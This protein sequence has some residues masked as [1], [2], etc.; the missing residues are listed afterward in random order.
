MKPVI[1]TTAPKTCSLVL[2]KSK[3]IWLEKENL[4]RIEKENTRLLRKMQKIARDRG[5]VDNHNDYEPKSLNSLRRKHEVE[6]IMADNR[7]LVRRL[8]EKQR[9]K[10]TKQWEKEWSETLI[11]M[12]HI[13]R[14]PSTWWKEEQDKNDANSQEPEDPKKIRPLV[15]VV[16]DEAVDQVSRIDVNRMKI[17]RNDPLFKKDPEYCK[18]IAQE[19][20]DNPPDSIRGFVASI[21]QTAIYRVYEHERAITR[22]KASQSPSDDGALSLTAA[23]ILEDALKGISNEPDSG[24][25]CSETVHYN[26]TGKEEIRLDDE[27]HPSPNIM[28][29]SIKDFTPEIGLKKIEE[30]IKGW[31]VN[32]NWLHCID[33]L[34]VQEMPYDTHY[35]YRVRWSMPTRRAPIPIATASVYFTIEVSRVKPKTHTVGVFYQLEANRVIHRPGKTQF[36]EQWLRDIVDSKTRLMPYINF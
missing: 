35:R 13:S 22:L 6:R 3:K 32:G 11:Y 16:E 25:E 18:I 21:I 2:D 29:P 27:Q 36:C 1:D 8:S 33:I 4:K 10:K 7:E 23:S 30:Y 24:D 15:E 26:E 14:H 34:D 31:N 12:D 17:D 9:N 28:W 5:Y 19:E 20:T